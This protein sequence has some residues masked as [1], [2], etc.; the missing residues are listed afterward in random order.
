VIYLDGSSLC[1]FLPGVRHGEVWQAWVASH[2]GQMVTSQLGLT[3]LRQAAALYPRDSIDEIDAIIERVRTDVPVTRFSDDKVS[4]SSHAN[5]VLKPFA[6]LHI[7]A[8]VGDERVDTIATY[9]PALAHVAEI[10]RLKVVT[11]GLDEKWYLEFEGPVESWSPIDLDTPYASVGGELKPKQGFTDPFEEALKDIESAPGPTEAEPSVAHD[12]TRDEAGDEAIVLGLEDAHEGMGPASSEGK[13]AEGEVGAPISL[14]EGPAGPAALDLEDVPAEP[15]VAPEPPPPPSPPPPSKAPSV[16]GEQETESEASRRRAE[17]IASLGVYKPTVMAWEGEGEEGAGGI[18]R[19]PNLD[20]APADR[21]PLVS[22]P[23]PTEAQ[24]EAQARPTPPQPEKPAG[25]PEGAPVRRPLMDF[26]PE[27]QEEKPKEEEELKEQADAAPSEPSPP[28]EEGIPA[29][30][31]PPIQVTFEEPVSYAPMRYDPTGARPL[32]EAHPF[33]RA[34]QTAAMEAAP[35]PPQQVPDLE[36]APPSEPPA[37][38][39]PIGWEE[40]PAKEEAP[41]PKKE[42]EEERPSKRRRGKDGKKRQKDGK[43]P[44]PPAPTPEGKEDEDAG[45]KLEDI[46][47]RGSKKGKTKPS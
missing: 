31:L 41:T 17:M 47:G 34:G 2:K 37:S 5:A 26:T 43:P 22:R 3:E 1:R 18:A 8:A 24:E 32:P 23:Q 12:K 14:E 7:G 42:Q 28:D 9:D 38:V 33:A 11:P 13:E 30:D 20:G 29:P 15:Q 4:I 39:R 46:I 21:E 36:P 16:A 44:E 6:A 35:I 40:V 45:W 25:V 10:Y 19:E 27:V